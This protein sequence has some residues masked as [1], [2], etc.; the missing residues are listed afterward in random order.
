MDT[1]QEYLQQ[2]L[3]GSGMAQGV[4]AFAD[5]NA[6]IPLAEPPPV[7]ATAEPGIPLELSPGPP[8]T[9]EE[10]AARK[11]AWVTFI[12]DLKS[13]PAKLMMLAK[14]GTAA[15]QPIPAGQTGLGHFGTAV[16]GSIDYGQQYQD[17]VARRQ[18]LGAQTKHLGAETITEGKRPAQVEATTGLLG[19]EKGLQEAKTKT[20]NE[21]RAANIAHIEAGTGALIKQG[22]LSQAQADALKEDAKHNPDVIKA[23]IDKLKADAEESRARGGY[24]ARTGKTEAANVQLIEALEGAH[25]IADADLVEMAKTNL[26]RAKAMA[27]LRANSGRFAASVTGEQGAESGAATLASLETA[28]DLAVAGKDKSV[29]S[30]DRAQWINEQ[31][32]RDVL[33]PAK[34]KDEATKAW[35]KKYGGRAAPG[36]AATGKVGRQP[37]AE[38]RAYA[39]AHPEKRQAFIDTF[40]VEP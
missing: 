38:D 6:G 14:F 2:L 15:M 19:A 1:S 37:T 22:V 5:P 36:E 11:N 13:D 27:K 17:M 26:P 30:M 23:T 24:Y 12:D 8:K 7:G 10:H 20:E 3:G 40:G 33:M 35:L 25:L 34:Q 29:K 21:G 9:D 18:L 31:L 4:G 28:Y 39:K 16:Q 32:R